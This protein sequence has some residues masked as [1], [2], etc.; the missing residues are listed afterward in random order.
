MREILHENERKNRTACREEKRG[1]RGLKLKLLL[2]R[3][4]GKYKELG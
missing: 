1:R 2:M 3:I 4:W